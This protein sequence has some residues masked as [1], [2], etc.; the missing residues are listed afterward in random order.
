MRFDQVFS[1]WAL[2]MLSVL[3]ILSGLLFLEHG[4]AKYLRFPYVER[5]DL[6]DPISLTG[7][8]GLIELVLGPL[9]VLGLFTRPVAFILS[10]EMAAAYFIS[11]APRSFFPLLNGGD[12]A[13]LYCFVFLYFVFAG[14]GPWSIDALW[15]PRAR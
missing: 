15:R 12:S 7:V 1:A 9:L 6:L 2:R 8:A 13:V 5:Y 10:G 11:H 4:T 3:R 14:G